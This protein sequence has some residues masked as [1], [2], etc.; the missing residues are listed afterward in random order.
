MP[1]GLVWWL[2]HVQHQQVLVIQRQKFLVGH[3][4][5]EFTLTQ[6]GWGVSM[7]CGKNNG[8]SGMSGKLCHWC[9]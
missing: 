3:G 8:A 9:L 6:L 2:P 7:G 4:Q 5:A 1:L